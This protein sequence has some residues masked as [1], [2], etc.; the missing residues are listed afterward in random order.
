MYDHGGHD[1]S[2][3]SCVKGA[4]PAA[5]DAGK[6][7]PDYEAVASGA[8]VVAPY[9]D[10]RKELARGDKLLINGQTLAVSANLTDT[11]DATHVPLAAPFYGATVAYAVA[12]PLPE[13]D[14]VQNLHCTAMVDDGHNEPRAHFLAGNDVVEQDGLKS[15]VVVH[16][17]PKVDG[18]ELP[19]PLL[20]GVRSA[21][22]LAARVRTA[23]RLPSRRSAGGA[24][25]R[26]SWRGG[27]CATSS[28]PAARHTRRVVV[29][30][31]G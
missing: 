26:C 19:E 9:K 4:D 14:E 30:V 16:D 6:T 11:F 21:A 2:V 1:C 3:I 15:V 27:R 13:V 25:L 18:R 28:L 20:R 29:L 22:D 31:V 10:L 5:S 24:E 17:A 7:L 23:Q 12:S 8:S